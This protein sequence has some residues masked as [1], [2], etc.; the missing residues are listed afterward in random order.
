MAEGRLELGD[1]IGVLLDEADTV[2][3][4]RLG[5]SVAPKTKHLLAELRACLDPVLVRVSV[6]SR[7]TCSACRRERAEC[8]YGLLF[9]HH[10][11]LLDTVDS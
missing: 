5:V 8:I 2:Q 9:G 1:A 3:V 7:T 6:I 10:S 11:D 4:A